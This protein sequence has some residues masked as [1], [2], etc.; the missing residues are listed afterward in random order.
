M[1]HKMEVRSKE[2]KEKEDGKWRLKL[3]GSQSKRK[4][5]VFCLLKAIAVVGHCCHYPF[6]MSS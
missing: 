6:K 3:S 1:S 5:D 4:W 2:G